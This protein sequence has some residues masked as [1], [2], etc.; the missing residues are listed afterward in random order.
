MAVRSSQG[1][2]FRYNAG[3]TRST[4]CVAAT[5]IGL[6]IVAI[7]HGG[8]LH[9]AAADGDEDLVARLLKTESDVNEK[10]PLG[11][12]PL[13]YAAAAGDREVAELL[14]QRGAWRGARDENGQTPAD[15]A[16]SR[17]EQE[18]AELLRPRDPSGTVLEIAYALPAVALL[19]ILIVLL[20]H[21]RR[22]FRRM[23]VEREK[24]EKRWREGFGPEGSDA[25]A[26]DA[27]AGQVD[28]T[29]QGPAGG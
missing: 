25:E 1:G 4:Q 9:R 10:D 11:R 13:H 20:I 27:P 8:P 17:G 28:S 16:R 15:I 24:L 29:G 12:T 22:H 23:K 21:R 5:L 26:P 6:T 18:L 2:P 7:A 14:L 3:M 19:G